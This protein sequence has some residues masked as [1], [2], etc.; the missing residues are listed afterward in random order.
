MK[1]SAEL[2][3][4]LKCWNDQDPTNT[5]EYDSSFLTHLLEAVF[6]LETLAKSS[7]SGKRSNNGGKK[8][9]KLDNVLLTFV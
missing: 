6:G 5:K 2:V 9:K 8:H 4:L 3:D 7:V 1:L